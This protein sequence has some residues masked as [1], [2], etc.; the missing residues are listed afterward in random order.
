LGAV[1]RVDQPEARCDRRHLPSGHRLLGDHRHIRRQ[2]SQRW[3]DESFRPL[4]RLGHRRG[5]ILAP[6]REVRRVDLHDQLARSADD[7][8]QVFEQ[9]R[10]VW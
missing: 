3:Q 6:N 1:E 8:Q 5:I 7:G 4:V 2:C 10:A 9:I